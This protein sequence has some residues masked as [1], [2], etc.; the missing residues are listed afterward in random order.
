MGERDHPTL[1]ALDL[2]RWSDRGDT[3]SPR[4]HY[5]HTKE[6]GKPPCNSSPENS[7]IQRAKYRYYHQLPATVPLTLRY[8]LRAQMIVFTLKNK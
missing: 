5:S 6:T 4:A 8:I 3:H 7:N 2:K 1:I